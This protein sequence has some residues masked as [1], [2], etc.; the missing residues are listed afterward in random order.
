MVGK[1]GDLS[2]LNNF[3]Y[4]LC[5]SASLTLLWTLVPILSKGQRRP[6]GTNNR[7][8]YCGRVAIA[9]TVQQR[10]STGAVQE[11]YR[12]STVLVYRR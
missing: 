3:T 7:W 9:G 6:S 2:T 12:S 4:S 10:S 8:R 1:A 5:D 11:Q